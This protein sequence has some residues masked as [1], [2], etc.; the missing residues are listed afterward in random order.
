MHFLP[1]IYIDINFSNP[2]ISY[3]LVFLGGLAGS[4]SPCSLYMI[5]LIIGFVGGCSEASPKKSILYSFFFSIGISITST[6]LG[7]IAATFGLFLGDFGSFWKYLL[8]IVSFIMGLNMMGILKFQIPAPKM[9]KPSQKGIIASLFAGMFFGLASS[10]CATPALAFIL[11][12]VASKRD[13]FYGASLFFVY[14]I[15][16]M[17]LAFILGSGTGFLN[18]TFKSQKFQKFSEYFLKIYGVFI[19]IYGILVLTR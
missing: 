19:I 12:F 8:S 3:I 17:L 6:I 7:I 2:I 11:V 15:A 5:P 18:A 9:I 13:I 16:N 1:K 10:P 4:I 14:S